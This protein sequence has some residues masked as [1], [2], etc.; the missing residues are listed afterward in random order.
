MKE[1]IM[2]MMMPESEGEMVD[3]GLDEVDMGD[4]E[5]KEVADMIAKLEALGYRVEKIEDEEI[6]EDEMMDEEV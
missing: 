5:D 2:S 1:D 6:P 4:S 3:L